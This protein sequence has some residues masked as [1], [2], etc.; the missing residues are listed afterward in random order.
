VINIRTFADAWPKHVVFGCAVFI[1]LTVYLLTTS[2]TVAF[3]DAGEL[4]LRAHQLG[5]T[6]APGA[7]LFVIIGHGFG[8]VV[9]NPALAANLI[10]VISSSV[11]AGLIGVL[12]YSQTKTI[13]LSVSGALAFAAN[14]TIWG[15]AI[16]SEAY[17]LSLL[18]IA[19]STVLVFTWRKSDQ[20]AFP[21]C[22]ALLY[23][24]SL[25]A[26][27]ANI[28]LLPAYFI[29]LFFSNNNGRIHCIKFFI[30]TIIFVVLTAICNIFLTMNH[31]PF[32]SVLPDSLSTLFLYMSGSQHDPL[33]LRDAE[34]LWGRITDHFSMF[35]QNY[36]Y[37]FVPL[38]IIGAGRTYLHDRAIGLFLMLIFFIYMGYFTLFGAGDYFTMVAPA[39]FVFSFWAVLGL[40]FVGKFILDERF[41]WLPLLSLVVIT[42]LSFSMQF[43]DRYREAHSAYAE[44]YVLNAFAVIPD[45]S[46]VVA[47]WN[48]FTALS[49]MQIVK[50]KRADLRMLVPA[51][52][53]RL[54]E[55]GAVQDYLEYIGEV[56]CE[57]PVVTNK[58]TDEI[59]K[60]Y[61]YALISD[62]WSWYRL[63]SK[64]PCSKSG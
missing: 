46:I 10:S 62:E 8:W 16:L 57:S 4:A 22:V 23:G 38:G 3:H 48:E 53:T 63:H 9:P 35:S 5:A 44:R 47:R 26:H 21:L 54:Y 2:L 51:R 60:R 32:G 19:W 28:L 58:L 20:N 18:L 36:W 13:T 12:L 7:P 41:Q 17:A 14:F 31:V 56:I 29:L 25:G 15:N 40:V 30:T 50:D 24:F 1:S 11:T 45:G 49:Y 52:E 59:E 6:H 39:Y 64:T 37:V 61:R 42:V 43:R 55:Y 27:F 34:F 33:V